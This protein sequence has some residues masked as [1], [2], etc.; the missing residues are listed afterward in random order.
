MGHTS[1]NREPPIRPGG[2]VVFKR[3]LRAVGVGGPTVDT[4]L[5]NP[6]TRPGELLTGEVRIAGGDHPA[7]IDHVA[8]SLVTRVEFEG[9]DSETVRNV[10]YGKV[11]VAQRVTVAPGQ[12]MAIPF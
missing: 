5:T 4:V 3:M 2:P 8:L 9:S 1:P 11:F 10:D 6:S 12:Q 7:D